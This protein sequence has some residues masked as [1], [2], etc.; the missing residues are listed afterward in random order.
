MTD[1]P[2]DALASRLG[3]TFR[4]P[5]LLQRALT[6]RS[7]AHEERGEP[8]ASYERLE[9]LGDALLGFLVSD[10]LVAIDPDAAEGILT[11]RRQQLVSTGSLARAAA[12]LG[13]GDVLRLGRGEDATGG[14]TKP[15]L[16]AD[17]FESILA[18]VYL[19]GGV[20]PARAFVKRHLGD[21][22]EEVTREKAAVEDHKTR[23]Q[24]RVQAEL[25]RRPNYRIVTASGPDHARHFVVEVW[26]GRK[27]LGRGAGSSRKRAE[28]GAAAAAL[29]AMDAADASEETHEH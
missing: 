19:D 12:D 23:L 9:F 17:V 11:R 29:A 8:E 25:R 21:R 2:H 26:I 24:E 14:R 18:A 13:L 10:R 15:S 22:I 7:R 5:A 20:R 6:H 28:Q 16:L 27:R 1:K 3:Y 4:D